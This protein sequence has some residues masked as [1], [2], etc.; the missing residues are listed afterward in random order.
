[1]KILPKSTE[2]FVL[3]TRPNH[4]KA[5]SNVLLRKGFNAFCP[6][7]TDFRKYTDR[8]KKVEAPLFPNYIFINTTFI[9]RYKAFIT[10]GIIRYLDSNINPTVVPESEITLIKR[11]LN[12]NCEVSNENFRSGDKVI[13]T[14]GPLR[15]L[16]GTLVQIRGG[17]RLV[18][19][20]KSVGKNLLVDISS[21]QIKTVLQEV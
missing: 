5:I 16:E 7:R 19:A 15:N 8:I 12:Q 9:D 2:W 4:E 10:P 3:F 11:L 13:I 6:V 1:M 14:S 17:R 21:Y 18:V 20:I